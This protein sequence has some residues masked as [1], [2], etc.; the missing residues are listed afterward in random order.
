MT[1]FN[2]QEDIEN[3]KKGWELARLKALKEEEERKA[4][5]EDDEML[6]I[7]SK[8][9]SQVKKKGRKPLKNKPKP[10][11]P[12]SRGGKGLLSESDDEDYVCKSL[13][14]SKRASGR[15]SPQKV[16]PKQNVKSK[17]SVDK[18]KTS[19]GKGKTGK[20]GRPKKTPT[21]DVSQKKVP[22]GPK[23]KDKPVVVNGETPTGKTKLKVP[24]VVLNGIPGTPKEKKVKIVNNP[25]HL[26]NGHSVPAT[27]SPGKLATQKKNALLKQQ[28]QQAAHIT[29]SASPNVST[30]N[31]QLKQKLPP[32]SVI[33][34][35]NLNTQSPQRLQRPQLKP[36]TPKSP[37]IDP[38]VPPPWS[39]PNLVIR[40]RK[41]AV[42]SPVVIS[43]ARTSQAQQM[44]QY[45]F[46]QPVNRPQLVTTLPVSAV[47]GGINK[48]QTIPVSGNLAQIQS[49]P[50]SGGNSIQFQTS[51]VQ[52][53]AS[54]VQIQASPVKIQASPVKIQA[55]PIKV[56]ASSLLG[57]V[58]KV[59][60][61]PDRN[62]FQIFQANTPGVST[63]GGITQN[64]RP[65]GVGNQIRTATLINPATIGSLTGARF[66]TTGLAGQPPVVVSAPKP[67]PPVN[68]GSSVSNITIMPSILNASSGQRIITSS[69]GPTIVNLPG[70]ARQV[71]NTTRLANPISIQGL[72]NVNLPLAVN[73]MKANN[74]S[75]SSPQTVVRPQQLL[76][77]SQLAQVAGQPGYFLITPRGARPQAPTGAAVTPPASGTLQRLQTPISIVQTLPVQNSS[78]RVLLAQVPTGAK[79]VQA[80]HIIKTT[81]S[82]TSPPQPKAD[83]S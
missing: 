20:V 16:T 45:V 76:Q 80:P 17:T 13:N 21:V 11:S 72:G 36:S 60:G 2:F 14:N 35:A 15:M 4:E 58:N 68:V 32:C 1:H 22:N 3:S 7:Y 30:A 28:A 77:T 83:G 37:V 18:K 12:K 51:P 29:I 43:K 27:I 71:L 38:N 53:Q 52:I 49:L 62:I 46:Q 33:A 5:L 74:A 19:V 75:M 9:D 40:T 66:L 47:S 82:I 26:Q 65:V 59:Q 69:S 79:I 39:N 64:V 41:A 70:G 25:V 81:H 44:P 50:G 54:P 67:N 63:L 57:G 56:Q 61:T 10:Q 23:S 42:H 55:S 34:N 73:L 8:D 24:K 48:L 6:Y 31:V 78:G